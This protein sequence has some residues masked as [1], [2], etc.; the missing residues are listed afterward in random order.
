[1][2][3]MWTY[4]ILSMLSIPVLEYIGR[5]TDISPQLDNSITALHGTYPL[6]KATSTLTR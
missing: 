4:G 2:L 5:S 3:G 6:V 1:M